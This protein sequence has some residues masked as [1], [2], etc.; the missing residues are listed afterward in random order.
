MIDNY[1]FA[2][3]TSTMKQYYGN[4]NLMRKYTTFFYITILLGVVVKL[5]YVFIAYS[6]GK[7]HTG[8]EHHNDNSGWWSVWKM[9]ACWQPNGSPL[10]GHRVGAT[11]GMWTLRPFTTRVSEQTR[12]WSVVSSNKLL[13]IRSGSVAIEADSFVDRKCRWRH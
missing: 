10:N 4:I 2:K 6:A 8:K 12:T 9:A 13:R 3:R 11:F 5:I 1:W 7:L